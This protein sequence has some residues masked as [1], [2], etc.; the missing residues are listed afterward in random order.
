MEQDTSWPGR[1]RLAGPWGRRRPARGA[2]RRPG[3]MGRLASAALVAA[4]LVV[5]ACGSSSTSSGGGAGA[6][7][8][9][10]A[11]GASPG[12]TVKTATINGATVLTN[13]KGFTVYSFAP[14]TP[15]TSRCNGQCAKYWPPVKGP[16][17]AGPGSPARSPPSPAQTASPR[18]PMTGIR[19]TPTSPTPPPARPRGTASTS[20]AG[21]GTRSPHPGRP[22]RPRLPAEAPHPG[23]AATGTDRAR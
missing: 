2:E 8:S 23:E 7:S 16:V 15:T 13:A 10:G 18:P 19:S 14:D 17:T 6:A 1:V 21:S 20:P 11:G 3:R 22:H 5:A 4:A 9:A 12:T